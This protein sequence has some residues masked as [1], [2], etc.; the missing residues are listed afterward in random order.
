[1]GKLKSTERQV[2]IVNSIMLSPCLL[3]WKLC[4]F[5]VSPLLD[6]TTRAKLCFLFCLGQKIFSNAK[7]LEEI[8][9]RNTVS[10]WNAVSLPQQWLMPHAQG[11]EKKLIK[12]ITNKYLIW[13]KSNKK[14][15]P[16]NAYRANLLLE[17]WIC[18]C[19]PLSL[20]LQLQMLLM[21]MQLPISF[22]H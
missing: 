2:V 10:L 22:K 15:I 17:Q 12:P 21:A 14:P 18:L 8:L 19:F 3:F 20:H 4:W 9:I 7:K 5:S 13:P 6:C 1:M 11:K 16:S